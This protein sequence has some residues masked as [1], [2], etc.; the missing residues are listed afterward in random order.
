MS[1]LI[2]ISIIKLESRTHK[3]AVNLIWKKKKNSERERDDY[4]MKIPINLFES[5]DFTLSG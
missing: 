2:L 3:L 4:S 5:T 1:T